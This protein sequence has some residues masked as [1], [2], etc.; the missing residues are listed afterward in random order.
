MSETLDLLLRAQ[1]GSSAAFSALFQRHRGRL[2]AL[3]AARMSPRLRQVADAEDI[4]QEASVEATRKFADFHAEV[5]Q[6]FYRW[7]ARIADF[8]LKEAERAIRAKKRGDP[9]PL[10]GEPAMLQTSVGAR[11]GARERRALLVAALERL[12]EAQAQ[13][14]QLRYLEGCTLAETAERLGRSE[15]AVKALVSR[16]LGALARHTSRT[17]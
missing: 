10:V 3:V 13:A 2:C 1:D 7:L 6:A 12:P 9:K 8:K 11:A 4:V 17:R 16:G 15:A 5:P 14:V